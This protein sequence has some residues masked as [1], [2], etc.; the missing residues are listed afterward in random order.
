MVRQTNSKIVRE[1]DKLNEHEA[2]AVLDYISELLSNRQFPIPQTASSSENQFN[3]DLIAS[4]SEKRENRCA[5]Q[6]VEW[7]KIRRRSQIQR[8]A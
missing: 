6:V 3:D 7:E 5:Q 8:A 1:V 4:L 2:L